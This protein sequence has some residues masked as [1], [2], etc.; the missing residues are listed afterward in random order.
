MAN[1]LD[2]KAIF[3][4]L[5]TGKKVTIGFTNTPEGNAE[6]DKL[7]NYLNVMKSRSKSALEEFGFHFEN[8]IFRVSRTM[9]EDKES[10]MAVFHIEGPKQAKKYTVFS[11]EDDNNSKDNCGK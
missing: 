4:I 5:R 1:E 9:T 3:D 6:E 10:Y 11:I 8:C 2:A 7:V